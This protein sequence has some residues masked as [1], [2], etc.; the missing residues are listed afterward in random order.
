MVDRQ[1]SGLHLNT[2]TYGYTFPVNTGELLK[3]KKC[4]DNTY[5]NT[6]SVYTVFM[7]T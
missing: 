1:A 3:Y 4:E 6:Y 2:R 5:H 7:Y